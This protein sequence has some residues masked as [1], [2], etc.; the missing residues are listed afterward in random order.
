VAKKGAILF[1]QSDELLRHG[2]GDWDKESEGF[3]KRGE[4]S[5]VRE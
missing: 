1:Q 2:V 4:K 3:V 5:G